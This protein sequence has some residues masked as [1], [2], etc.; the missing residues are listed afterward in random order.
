MFFISMIDYRIYKGRIADIGIVG[1]I[2]LLALVFVPGL[3][4]TRNDATRWLNIGIQFQPSEI[5]KVAIIIFLSAKISKYPESINRFWKGMLLYLLLLGVIA[6]LLLF[7]PHMSATVI[8]LIISAS[9]MFSAGLS[10]KYIIPVGIGGVAACVVLALT[11]EYRMKRVMIF[12]DPWQDKLGDGWQIIQ[13]IYA[14]ASGGLFGVGLGKS[15][16]KYMYIPEPH[17]DFIF[18][19]LSEE[20]GFI[21]ALG[22]IALFAIF[23]WRGIVIAMKAPD[24]FGSLVAIGITSL[25]GVQ[26][27]INIAVVTSSMPVTGMQLPFFSYGGTALF[28]LLCEMGVLL[29]ISR[30]SSKQ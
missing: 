1:A 13:S 29:S 9:I 2:I 27:I 16:Q 26:V 14:I 25:V 21:G 30:A 17:N 6:G 5:M 7:E 19:I 4:V 24:M 8:I 23:I 11:A 18:A 20:L 10:W 12:L 28:L 15:T 22:V 3:G